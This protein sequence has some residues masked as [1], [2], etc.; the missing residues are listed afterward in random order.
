MNRCTYATRGAHEEQCYSSAQEGSE[1]GDEIG[2]HRGENEEKREGG[3]RQRAE[4]EGI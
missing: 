2:E 3:K 1:R 4:K